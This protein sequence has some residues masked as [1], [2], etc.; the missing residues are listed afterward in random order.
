MILHSSAVCN[1]RWESITRSPIRKHLCSFSCHS[2]PVRK[3]GPACH[4]SSEQSPFWTSPSA[5]V[6]SYMCESQL[7]SELL[8][9]ESP[10]DELATPTIELCDLG[11]FAL[12]PWAPPLVNSKMISL[13]SCFAGCHRPCTLPMGCCSGDSANVK[14]FVCLDLKPLSREQNK[15]PRKEQLSHSDYHYLPGTQEAL[16]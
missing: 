7:K 9:W 5:C 4:Q 1:F 10:G 3:G 6:T 14:A 15:A 12:P 11:C 2:S 8:H 13:E 16:S